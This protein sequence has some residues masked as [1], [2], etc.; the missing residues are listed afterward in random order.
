MAQESCN[1][2]NKF[3]S[4]FC[5][6]LSFWCILK[7]K[8]VALHPAVKMKKKKVLGNTYVRTY[9]EQ[10]LKRKTVSI[11]WHGKGRKKDVRLGENKCFDLSE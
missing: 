11:L 5:S 7:H 2:G 1:E 3:K 4:S 6:S 10:G 8:S 9:V